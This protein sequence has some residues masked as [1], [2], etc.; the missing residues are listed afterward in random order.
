MIKKSSDGKIRALS[1][2][3][4]KDSMACL[5]AI[6]KLG[7]SLDKIVTAE[8]WATDDIQAD[9]PPM[10]EFKEK[11][12]KII[13]ERYGL[14]V[15][16]VYATKNFP[17]PRTVAGGGINAHTNEFSTQKLKT[18]TGSGQK[19]EINTS[20]ENATTMAANSGYT[21]FRSPLEHGAIQSSKLPHLTKQKMSYQSLL[22]HRNTKGPNVG[23]LRGFA[24][25]NGNWCTSDLKTG[26]LGNFIK[27]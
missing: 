26:V 1:L 21:D 15:T 18:K 24:T 22:Y 23:R 3:Y 4:G 16:H 13:K 11:A 25:M 10:V 12:D 8:I 27:A 9:L 6:E 14:D 2:S 17:M 5:G 20:V 7:W 19:G